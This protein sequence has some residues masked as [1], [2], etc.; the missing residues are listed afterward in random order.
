MSLKVERD[1]VR[2]FK[3]N[4]LKTLPC[5][6]RVG[7]KTGKSFDHIASF[8]PFFIYIRMTETRKRRKVKYRSLQMDK[9]AIVLYHI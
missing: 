1:A 4:E 3:E 6:S 9:K 8:L 7:M 2:K 5:L